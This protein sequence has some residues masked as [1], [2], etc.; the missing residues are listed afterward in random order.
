M[1]IDPRLREF[2]FG[3]WEGLTWDEITRRWPELREHGAMAAKRYC[4]EGGERFED[5]CVRTQSFIEDIRARVDERVLVV[6]HAGILHAVLD[7]L[8][9][10]IVGW[11]ADGLRVAFS[12][13]SLT[14]MTFDGEQARLTALNDIRHLDPSA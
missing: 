1:Q 5:V 11:P 4:P 2:D 10:T 13:A 14:R 9:A 8:G 7:V 6:T 3:A 12:Q